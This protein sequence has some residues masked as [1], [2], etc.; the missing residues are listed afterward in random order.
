M[1]SGSAS[2]GKASGFEFR[3]P[4]GQG[5]ADDPGRHG[6]VDSARVTGY[7]AGLL[8]RRNRAH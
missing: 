7:V 2:V 5:R 3:Y 1:R 6:V 8:A 4:T